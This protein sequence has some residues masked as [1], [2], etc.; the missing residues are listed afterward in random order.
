[1]KRQTVKPGFQFVARF[2]AFSGE[3]VREHKVVVEQDGTVRVY[4]DV[5]GHYT[6]C[7]SIAPST[8]GKLRA[9][10]RRWRD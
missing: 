3:P 8:L 7:H 1:M 9:Y 6:T 10:A 4:D 5:A 2:R